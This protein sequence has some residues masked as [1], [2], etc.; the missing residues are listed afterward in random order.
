[1]TEYDKVIRPGGVGHVTASIHTTNFKGD[2]TKSVTVTTNDPAHLTTILQIKVNVR[3]PIDVQP[4]D[5]VSMDGKP[6]DLKPTVLTVSSMGGETF[7]ITA[8]DITAAGMKVEVAPK[9]DVEAGKPAPAAPKPK[10]GTVASGAKAY[11]V[12]VTPSADMPI[13][14]VNGQITLKTTHPKAAEVPIRVFVNVRG[15]VEATPERVTL[16]LGASVPEQQ[17]TAHVSIKKTQGTPLKVT[18]VET[19]N[20]AVKTNLKTVTEGKEFDLEIKYDGPAPTAVVDAD[21]TVKTNDPKQPT[22]SIKAYAFP[23][24]PQQ[25][26]MTPGATPQLAPGAV[27][28]ATAPGAPPDARKLEA[29]PAPAP[30]KPPASKPPSH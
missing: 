1:M 8:A 26:A 6:G 5:T 24:A 18:G 13:G 29:K 19:S 7:D 20:P 21:V 30:A 11:T 10:A 14:R 15:D 22:L 4:Q 25:G 28:S 2:L 17:K 23:E 3:V 16:R 12:T 9:V 27:L